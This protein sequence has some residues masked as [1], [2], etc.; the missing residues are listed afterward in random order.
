MHYF[1]LT[2]RTWLR[3]WFVVYEQCYGSSQVVA[4][5]RERRHAL[6]FIAMLQKVTDS[7]ETGT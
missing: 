1:T 2:S 7:M 6:A 4:K 3:R 5:F